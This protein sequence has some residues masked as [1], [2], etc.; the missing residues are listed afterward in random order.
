M[1]IS[2]K[3][4]KPA[5]RD[6]MIAI[7]E[8]SVR[9]THYFLE[10]ED[11]EFYKA[12]VNC[13]DFSSLD[14]YCAF[15]QGEMVGIMGVAEDKLEMLFLKPSSIGNGIGR[16]LMDFALNELAVNKVDVNE[17]NIHAVKFYERLGFKEYDRSSV[18]DN[19]KPYP[20]IRMMLD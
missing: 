8:E 11:I 2:I 15:E 6:S 18:D 19:G 12:Q 7:W 14:A 13:I 16:M 10:R 9:A 17:D 20:I 1:D 3:K 5:Y 4:Y